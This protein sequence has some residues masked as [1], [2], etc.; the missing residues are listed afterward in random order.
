MLP[1]YALGFLWSPV[2]LSTA[3]TAAT[4]AEPARTPIHRLS[5]CG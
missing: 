5:V 4:T 2:F 1:P 3:R